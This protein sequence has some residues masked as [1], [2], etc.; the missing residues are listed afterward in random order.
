MQMNECM[1]LCHLWVEVDCIFK[2]QHSLSQPTFSSPSVTLALRR[3]SLCFH[4]LEPGKV[5]DYRE[6]MPH[7]FQS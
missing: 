6:M 5:C 3:W 2:W 1:N 4:C 7:D